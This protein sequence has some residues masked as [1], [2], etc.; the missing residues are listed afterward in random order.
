M[1]GV[2]AHTR[3]TRARPGRRLVLGALLVGVVAVAVSVAV[4]SGVLALAGLVLALPPTAEAIRNLSAG[5]RPA[6]DGLDRR[7]ALAHR[8]LAARRAEEVTPSIPGGATV[9]LDYLP[10]TELV[11]FRSQD[12]G[13]AGFEELVAALDGAGGPLV[14]VGAPGSGKTFTARRIVMAFLEG[15]DGVGQRLAERFLLSRWD[16]TPLPD[17]LAREWAGRPDYQLDRAEA[18]ELIADPSVVLV[19]D[20]LDEVPNA[21]RQ[22]CVDTINAF[23]DVHPSIRLVVCCRSRE[24]RSLAERVESRRVRWIAPLDPATVATFI[25]AHGPVAWTR[26]HEALADDQALRAL[27]NTPLLLMAALRAF[28]DDPEPLLAGT[29]TERTHALWDG[30][31]DR[32]L[33]TGD[34]PRTPLADRRRKLEDVAITMA[35]TGTLELAHPPRGLRA[36]LDLCV[37]RHLLRR[38]AGGYQCLHR[39][40]LG[41]LVGGAT[42]TDGRYG[43]RSRLL[44]RVRS[45]ARAWNHLAR[46]AMTAGHHDAAIQLARRALAFEPDNPTFMSDLAFPLMLVGQL[47]EA[48]ELARAAEAAVPDD[49]RP[50]STLA[51]ALLALG[52]LEGAAAAR[53]RA[54]DKGNRISDDSFI[55]YVLTLQGLH[56]DAEAL[57]DKVR[58][59]AGEDTTR[60]D[61]ALALAAL[62]RTDEA[63]DSLFP[64]DMQSFNMAQ[65]YFAV[66]A[67][68][69]EALMPADVFELIE[70]EPGVAQLILVAADFRQGPWGDSLGF[71]FGLVARPRG[72]PED[73]LG[74]FV[75]DRTLNQQFSHAAAYRILALPGTLAGGDVVYTSDSVAFSLEINRQRTLSLRVPRVPPSVEPPERL[76]GFSYSVVGGVPYKTRE[77]VDLPPGVADPSAVVLELGTGPTADVLRSLG[78][79]RAPDACLWGEGLFMSFHLARPLEDG[80]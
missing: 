71:L 27:L 44:T 75:F 22:A 80:R 17:W 74:A 49:W 7:Q 73:T 37:D 31:V 26:V 19:L 52:D 6:G 48:V 14:L 63:T 9:D 79:P 56:D 23:V 76:D 40:L 53:R 35:T 54:W 55:A 45:E 77:V 16:G 3:Q 51:Y 12:D 50:T 32:M 4:R 47:D 46:E 28:R 64:V 11:T 36:F 18:D 68:A 1:T 38:S 8:M 59:T 62:G 69:A 70:H 42:F 78:L 39:Q 30:Y 65:L 66:P 58:A 34:Q 15:A 41:H 43:L 13:V 29:L 24:Y 5:F 25:A 61:H 72:A 67:A 60:M 57:L 20:G 2:P 10:E 33:Q 21:Q